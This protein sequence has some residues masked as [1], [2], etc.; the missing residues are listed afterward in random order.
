MSLRLLTSGEIALARTIFHNTINYAKVWVHNDTYFPFGLQFARTAMTPNGEMYYKKDIYSRD[1]SKLATPGPNDTVTSSSHL[2]IHEMTHV[3]QHQ[4]G[5]AVK[6][7]GFFSWAA[8][9]TYFLDGSSLMSYPMEQQA[10]IISDYWLLKNHMF[11]ANS[12]LIRYKG[13]IKENKQSL[14]LKYERVL[15]LF[16]WCEI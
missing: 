13:S 1:F 6:L 12:H 3:W 4:K 7:H 16:P 8:D 2:F 9:Y 14:I 5:Y 15:G 11:V 10:S